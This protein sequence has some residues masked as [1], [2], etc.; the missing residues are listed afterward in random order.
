MIPVLINNKIRKSG[1][2]KSLISVLLLLLAFNSV[3]LAQSEKQ[4]INYTD[5]D[6]K[7]FQ[8]DVNIKQILW[9]YG[10]EQKIGKEADF[11]KE[12]GFFIKFEKIEWTP[13]DG[14]DPLPVIKTQWI[15]AKS[16]FRV[17]NSRIEY[18]LS[19][20]TFKF[21]KVGSAEFS[22]RREIT[23]TIGYGHQED[24]QPQGYLRITFINQPTPKEISSN[25]ST[26]KKTKISTDKRNKPQSSKKSD[27]PKKEKSRTKIEAETEKSL[28]AENPISHETNENEEIDPA[29]LSAHSGDTLQSDTE[30]GTQVSGNSETDTSAALF[31]EGLNLSPQLIAGLFAFLLVLIYLLFRKKKT[32]PA[33]RVPIEAKSVRQTSTLVEASSQSS[34]TDAKVKI[35]GKI[36]QKKE[37]MAKEERIPFSELSAKADIMA[38]KL[39]MLWQDTSVQTVYIHPKALQEIDNFVREKNIGPFREEEGQVPEIAGFLLGRFQELNTHNQ[40]QVV[41][42]EF[43]PVTPG[44]QGVYM[45]EF[46]TH[47]WMEL[48]EVQEKY[49]DLTTIGWFHTHPGHGLFLSQPDLNIQKGFFRKPYHLA[50]EID[51]LREA[52]EMAFF[53]WTKGGEMNNSSKRIADS[54]FNWEQI[55]N[56]LVDTTS[57]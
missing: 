49:P 21:E 15:N 48:D 7:N 30:S 11:G 47:A 22:Q 8:A 3:L 31:L 40:Y 28:A 32:K 17:V 38:F 42:D 9:L 51:P 1:K 23:I 20:N 53:T 43:V 46:G 19:R 29:N 44:D 27:K 39:N 2:L 14:P 25:S 45:V 50:M 6:D 34:H 35:K 36:G 4:K 16:L 5:E 37:A 26:E 55:M 24:L 10:N 56:R 12:K 52:G 33:S 18:K 57:E 13:G 41:I 54:W